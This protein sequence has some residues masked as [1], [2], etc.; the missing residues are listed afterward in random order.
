[1]SSMYGSKRPRALL[2]A[3]EA[4]EDEDVDPKFRNTTSAWSLIGAAYE[5][6]VKRRRKEVQESVEAKAAQQTASNFVQAM[7][8]GSIVMPAM[9]RAAVSKS[10]VQV[11]PSAMIRRPRKVDT[12]VVFLGESTARTP[13]VKAGALRRILRR[14]LCRI[15]RNGDCA[16][17]ACF[18]SAHVFFVEEGSGPSQEGSKE[19]A[20]VRQVSADLAIE[21]LRASRAV[22][23]HSQS[24]GDEVDKNGMRILSRTHMESIQ[25]FDAL[26]DS[27]Q[28]LK[29][30]G[31]WVTP[32]KAATEHQLCAL[33]HHLQKRI[34]MMLWRCAPESR[35]R[36]YV[37]NVFSLDPALSE[38]KTVLCTVD[39]AARH[40]L[41]TDIC[42]TIAA[43]TSER[44]AFHFLRSSSTPA[45]AP[46]RNQPRVGGAQLE[47]PRAT[48]TCES[49]T[50]SNL[51]VLSAVASG[52]GNLNRPP[53]IN[54]EGLMTRRAWGPLAPIYLLWLAARAPR[55][56]APAPGMESVRACGKKGQV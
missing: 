23:D 14:E 11:G 22:H 3:H 55:R 33:A 25:D 12:E 49:T 56:A 9:L 15:A 29:R 10:K 16:H 45:P 41:G 8:S 31:K 52:T 27:L 4:V 35:D 54:T 17:L 5:A 13:S 43:D 1:M 2:A 30:L 20:A 42:I 36:R 38:V 26:I 7:K 46:S 47:A 18:V 44:S 48:E 6:E 50:L 24:R 53:G 28:Q 39:E 37:G 51:N 40:V 34:A 32:V 19:V 21:N